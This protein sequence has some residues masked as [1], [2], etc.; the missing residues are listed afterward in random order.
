MRHSISTGSGVVLSLIRSGQATTRRSLTNELGWSRITLGRRL[1]ELLQSSLIISVGQSDS[2]GGRP[3]EEFAVNPSAGLLLAVDIGGS[4]TRLAITDLVSNVLSQDEADIGLGEGPAEI[5]EWAGQVFDHMLKRLGKSHQDVVGIG[6]GVPGPVEQE[7]GRLGIPQ[8][9]PQWENVH[10]KE[11]FAERYGHAVFAVERD[12]NIMAI[13]EARRGW[14]EYTDIAVLKSG[15]GLGLAFVLDGSIYRGFRGGAGELRHPNPGKGP[16]R[17]EEA[18]SGEVIR[19]ELN[20]CGYKVRTSRDIV[21]LARRGDKTA[22]GLLAETGTLI[23]ETLAGV[24]SLLNPQAVV[25]GGI[26]SEA[27]E[28]FIATIRE[29][30]F[31]GAGDYALKGLVVETSRLGPAAGVTGAS[32]IA[33]DALFEPDRISRLTRNTSGATFTSLT[34]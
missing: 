24:V 22:L 30:I 16:Q 23:G 8:P 17:L 27:G 18:A 2:Q 15:I 4:H 3:P 10:V 13:A 29:S 34:G 6:V 14:R 32:L 1:D 20:K 33:Q 26:L 11:Y 5:F 19:R 28:A 31:A 25:I 7:T 9:D 12:V 21:D